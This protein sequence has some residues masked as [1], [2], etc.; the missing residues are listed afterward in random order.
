MGVDQPALNNGLGRL[1][2]R[3]AVVLAEREQAGG[4]VVAILD[5][6]HFVLMQDGR[7]RDA[8]LAGR[9]VELSPPD[10]GSRM[11]V[12][13]QA[14]RPEIGIDIPVVRSR[15]GGRG[16]VQCVEAA[17]RL[18]LDNLSPENLAV[19]AIDRHRYEFLP[20][21]GL[22]RGEK[23]AVAPDDGRRVSRRDRGLPQ[24]VRI[25]AE[26][27]GNTIRLGN[28]LPIGAAKLIPYSGPLLGQRRQ[29]G[30]ENRNRRGTHN[31]QSG[32]HIPIA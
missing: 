30:Q 20:V 9:R 29:A 14:V 18:G 32:A 2:D 5:Q 24:D 15:R 23:D 27:N 19:V 17:F 8:V 28:A 26:L 4:T 1:P 6:D 12:A 22:I 3:L 7:G 11:V 31:R 16:V 10:L 21:G 25:G 13:D